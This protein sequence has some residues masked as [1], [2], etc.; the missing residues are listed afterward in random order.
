MSNKSYLSLLGIFLL[1]LI[2]LSACSNPGSSLEE[3]ISPFMELEAVDEASNT[4]VVLNRGE[5]KGLDSYFAFDISNVES[6][7][8]V[9]EG[10][11]EGWCLEWNKP[12]AQNNDM[13]TGVEMYS[14]YG[15]STWKSANYL[16][17]I[18]NELKASDPDI[19]YKE[20]QVALWSL[21]ETPEF[22]LDKVLANNQMPSRLLTNG[23]P[24]FSVNKTKEIVNKVR[25]ESAD[26]NYGIGSDYFVF[27]RTGHEN[28][29]GGHTTTKCG[30]TAWSEGTKYG[31]GWATYT[32][33]NKIEKTINLYAGQHYE[34]GT[35]TFSEPNADD[36]VTITIDMNSTGG[37]QDV[38]NN[39]KIQGYSDTP[40]SKPGGLGGFDYKA[41]A[42][43][44]STSFSI[45]VPMYKNYG[46][47]VD[48]LSS[49]G[50]ED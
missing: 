24:N 21:I 7:S 34:I 18:K 12:I 17:N 26:F 37:F 45:D 5:T 44:S 40:P 28:Q 16:M 30:E 6:N 22:N 9:K 31:Q 14:T 46:V 36:M 43:A 8:L 49:E 27:A 33:Y 2:Y 50:C 35:V 13:H 25:S 48:A 19:T 32:P 11:V 47:H 29:N 1:S 4:T 23:Q 20:I 3:S 39:V 15:S 10:T 38:S 41:T 42:S